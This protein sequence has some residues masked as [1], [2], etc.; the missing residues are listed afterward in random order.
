MQLVVGLDKKEALV[1]HMGAMHDEYSAGMHADPATGAA[2]PRFV[3]AYASVVLHLKDV[4]ALGWGWGAV[5]LA[6]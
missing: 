1:I 5:F 6:L 4:S 3:N 2:D